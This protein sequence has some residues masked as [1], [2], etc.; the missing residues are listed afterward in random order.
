MQMIEIDLD[1]LRTIRNTLSAAVNYL[2]AQDLLESYKRLEDVAYSPLTQEVNECFDKVR[3][4][5][6]EGLSLLDEQE[7]NA[8]SSESV[9]E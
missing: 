3:G 7:S 5:I 1:D 8:E 2:I 4:I 6:A 9:A